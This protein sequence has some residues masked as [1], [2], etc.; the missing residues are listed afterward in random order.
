MKIISLS[1]KNLVSKKL[2]IKIYHMEIRMF[3]INFDKE[4]P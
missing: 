4:F 3:I 2:Y 1:L